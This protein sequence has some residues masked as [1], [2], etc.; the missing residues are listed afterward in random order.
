MGS[1]KILTIKDWYGT[2]KGDLKLE[3]ADY[4]IERL[5]YQSG[6]FDRLTIR[7]KP[8]Q[9]SSRIGMM[10][11]LNKNRGTLSW[12][13]AGMTLKDDEFSN[14]G[15]AITRR[16]FNFRGGAVESSLM[17]DTFEVITIVSNQIG[18]HCIGKC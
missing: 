9:Y 15:A 7:R 3:V 16:E 5:R 17:A 8:D 18:E 10:A 6:V 1:K 12:G 2:G 14:K 4:T 13:F 11:Y